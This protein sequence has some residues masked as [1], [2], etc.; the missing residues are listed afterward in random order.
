MPS[1]PFTQMEGPQHPASLLVPMELNNVLSRALSESCWNTN[2]LAD[3]LSFAVLSVPR[4]F[5][6]PGKYDYIIISRI[7]MFCIGRCN[8]I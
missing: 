7:H 4:A 1:T 3:N 8:S 6:K 2:P 5:T